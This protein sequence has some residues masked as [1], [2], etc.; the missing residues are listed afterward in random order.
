MHVHGTRFQV[1]ES[2]RAGVQTPAAY[3]SWKDTVIVPRGAT[4]RLRV[5]HDLPGL[6]MVH[7]HILEHEAQGMMG[8]LRVQSSP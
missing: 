8:V 3:L 5:R 1:V 7:C 6:R 2:E 4:V